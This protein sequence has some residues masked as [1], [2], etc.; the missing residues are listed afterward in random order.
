MYALETTNITK[1]FGGKTVV[2]SI[3]LKVKKGMIFGFLGRNGAGKSTFINMVTGVIRP[4]SGSCKLLGSE[5]IMNDKLNQ[6]VG[7][8]P[9]YSTFYEDLTALQ[10]LQ[11]FSNVIGVKSSKE[12][13][14]QLLEK[15]GLKDSIHVKA[16]KF[17]FGMKKKLGL[18]QA[19]VNDPDFII[20]DEPTSGVDAESVLNIHH[21]IKE[22]AAKGKTI[23]LTSHNLDEVEKLCDEIAIMKEGSIQCQGS[24]EELQRRHQ[25]SIVVKIKHSPIPVEDI[26]SIKTII[27]SVGK[28]LILSKEQTIVKVEN[29]KNISVI[30]RA[31]SQHQVD[32]Y[33]VEVDAP[34]LEEIFLQLGDTKNSA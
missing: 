32:V 16:K 33:R 34:T 3:N 20:L 27:E 12:D 10:H 31:F 8:L 29:E 28:D 6:K 14:I 24:M 30:N 13:L 26:S 1:V 5:N 2:D 22:L 19:L 17:S 18:A 25:E 9:D 23:F 4:S 7:V 11:F 21:I 15:V